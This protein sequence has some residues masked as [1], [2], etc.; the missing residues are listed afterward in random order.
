M[1]KMHKIPNNFVLISDNSRKDAKHAKFGEIGRYISLR[2][3]RSFG[4][5]QDRLGA[6][7]FVE[8]VLLNILSERIYSM[9]L[10][11]TVEQKGEAYRMNLGR[12]RCF[13]TFDLQS[14]P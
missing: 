6:K 14:W 9:S 11:L 13:A 7:I 3:W 8:V 5:A 12:N 2:S 4:H 1:I 10:Q